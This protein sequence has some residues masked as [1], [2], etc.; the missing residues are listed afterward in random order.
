MGSLGLIWWL[1]NTQKP[2]VFPFETPFESHL[3]VQT[4]DRK[5]EEWKNRNTFQTFHL[6]ASSKKVATLAI[7][8]AET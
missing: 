2:G 5:E 4:Q 7:R 1:H 3:L 8:E 6:H